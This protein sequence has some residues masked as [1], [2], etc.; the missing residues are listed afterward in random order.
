MF[1]AGRFL[2][3]DPSLGFRL[4]AE[5]CSPSPA[6]GWGTLHHQEKTAHALEKQGF[7]KGRDESSPD[8]LR[9]E[10]C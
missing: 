5:L 10:L 7:G 6:G 2:P 9:E 4:R 3:A 8:V 1:D